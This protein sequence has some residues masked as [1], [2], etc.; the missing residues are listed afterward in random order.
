MAFRPPVT[1]SVAFS[2][3]TFIRGFLIVR[4][5]YTLFEGTWLGFACGKF[6][7]CCDMDGGRKSEETRELRDSGIYIQ[8]QSS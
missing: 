4:P 6:G 3:R 2:V 7:L 1:R 8:E 5:S